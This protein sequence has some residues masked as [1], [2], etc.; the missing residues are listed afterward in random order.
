MGKKMDL[1]KLSLEELQ[2]LKEQ[3]EQAEAVKLDQFKGQKVLGFKLSLVRCQDKK[4]GKKYP[5]WK[6]YLCFKGKRHV[7]HIGQDP[8]DAMQKITEYLGKHPELGHL[9]R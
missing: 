4:S 3:L 7:V 8:R 1:K 9:S 6:A 2:K 5:S